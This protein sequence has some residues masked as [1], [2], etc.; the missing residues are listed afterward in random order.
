MTER[1][2]FLLQAMFRQGWFAISSKFRAGYFGTRTR[3][4]LQ[5]KLEMY[6]EKYSLLNNIEMIY[7]ILRQAKKDRKD[8]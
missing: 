1:K 7:K 3:E 2:L 8:V 6:S 5:R 4:K